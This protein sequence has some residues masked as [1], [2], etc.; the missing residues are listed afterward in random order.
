MKTIGLIGGT[1][2]ISTMQYYRLLNE[3]VNERLGGLSFAECVIYSFDYAQINALNQRNDSAGVCRL[4]LD[5]AHNLKNVGAECL[6][7]CANTL[8]QFADEGLPE[9]K[10]AMALLQ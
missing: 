10:K 2:W 1:G 9:V 4:V 7:L 5:A 6:M 8:H 3:M